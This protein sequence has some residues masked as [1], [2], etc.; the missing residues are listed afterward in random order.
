MC[1]QKQEEYKRLNEMLKKLRGNPCEWCN[2]TSQRIDSLE[3]E[4]EAEV[5][6]NQ[7][8]RLA[9]M[10]SVG[11]V[12][13]IRSFHGELYGVGFDRIESYRLLTTTDKGE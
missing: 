2:D 4:L 3:H 5:K 1:T 9:L 13:Y 10:D 8:L 7:A 12:A 6:E 11:A